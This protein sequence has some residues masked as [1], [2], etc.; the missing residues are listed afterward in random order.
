MLFNKKLASYLIQGMLATIQGRI[1]CFPGGCLKIKM[2][3]YTELLFFVLF[4]MGVKLGYL[5]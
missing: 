4:C 1:D 3:K 2:L 5:Y